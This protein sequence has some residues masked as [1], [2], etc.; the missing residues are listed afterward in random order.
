MSLLLVRDLLLFMILH[1]LSLIDFYT[2][3][4]PDIFHFLLV[5]LYISFSADTAGILH[6]FLEGAETASLFYMA[7]AASSRLFRKDTM[8]GGDIKLFFSAGMYLGISG[9]IICV[10]LSSFAGLLMCILTGK[11]QIPF[12]PCISFGFMN[13]ILFGSQLEKFFFRLPA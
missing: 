1:A 11:K 5:I 13:V 2:I 9:T 8:G 4:I 6:A 7:A 10:F 3:E 12:G